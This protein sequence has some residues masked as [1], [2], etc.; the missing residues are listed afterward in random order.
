MKLMRRL[1]FLIL[2]LG[3]AG[4]VL[5]VI[6][7]NKPAEGSSSI[8]F[9]ILLSGVGVGL[10]G[11]LLFGVLH[12]LVKMVSPPKKGIA[13]G[14]LSYRLEFDPKLDFEATPIWVLDASHC[15]PPWTPL[16]TW[17]WARTCYHGGTT[18]MQEMNL[19]YNPAMWMRAINGGV[20]YGF[21]I[22]ED[23][24]EAKEREKKFM[25]WVTPYIEDYENNWEGVPEKELMAMWERFKKFDVE[26]AT[27]SALWLHIEEL[28]FSFYKMWYY[29]IKWIY[30]SWSP[31]IL[32]ESVCKQFAGIDDSD[33]TFL[34]LVTGFDNKA[35]QI[36]RKMWKL[37]RRAVDL[38]LGDLFAQHSSS[39]IMSQL[40]TSEAGKEWI[41]E[42][43]EFLD[44]DG[45]RSQR[46]NDFTG[47]TW[48]EDP[49]PALDIIKLYLDQGEEFNLDKKMEKARGEREVVEKEIMEKIPDEM[50]EY[51]TKLLRLAQQ[52]GVHSESHI[53]YCEDY[54]YSLTR[55]A[56][57][58]LG[59]RYTSAGTLS[60]PD[61]IF[62]FLPEEM[63]KVLFEP[64]NFDLKP[65]AAERKKEH[66]RWHKKPNPPFLLKDGYTPDMVMPHLTRLANPVFWKAVLGGQRKAGPDIKA[67]LY[68]QVGSPG[69]AEGIAKVILDEAELFKVEEGD[70]LIA[71]NTGISWTPV[72]NLIKGAVVDMGGSLAHAAVV[73]REFG[74]PVVTNTLFGTQRIKTGQRIRVDGNMGV[75]YYLDK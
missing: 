50:Q 13:R 46:K 31:Y 26:N 8:G 32:L 38:G 43:S 7:L 5:G 52:A 47:P 54:A 1:G 51:F 41:G 34:K 59:R 16:A 63:L 72:F 70:I 18:V 3:V 35:F 4:I 30:I 48:I 68:G 19:P 28:L 22:I 64:Q 53:Y 15:V 23:E 21:P 6:F 36:D 66:E 49:T 74:I 69:V 40:L 39:E 11:F 25:A 2:L 57:L 73:G 20:Y 27:N 29:H 61:D 44:E 56:L 60:S 45:W 10:V 24:E 58:E 55:R 42:F 17:L 14:G 33:P 62:F 67:D 9:A 12:A 65:V 75:V 71:A 37:G